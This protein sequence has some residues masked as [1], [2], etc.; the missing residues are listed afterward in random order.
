MVRLFPER[1]ND[2]TI[3]ARPTSPGGSGGEPPNAAARGSLLSS[4]RFLAAYYFW[5][6]AAIG[7]YEPY[8][9]PFWQHLGFPPAQ[10][11]LLMAG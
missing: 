11:G 1:P 7:V 9:T 8:L 6:F 3:P 4:P 10:L 2:R 5:Y